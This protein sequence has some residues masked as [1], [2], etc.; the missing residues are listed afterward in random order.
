MK[1]LTL[2]DL[3]REEREELPEER[4]R[5]GDYES[6]P[7]FVYMCTMHGA[8]RVLYETTVRDAIRICEL[9]ETQGMGRGGP[10]FYA[11][12]T[13]ENFVKNGGNL[14]SKTHK[15]AD[16]GRFAGLFKEMGIQAV[17]CFV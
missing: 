15:Q 5:G 7:A 9:P 17:P 1:Q 16:D 6:K 14:E 8:G 4:D 13:Q 3:C 2:F 12:T 11:W 10:W